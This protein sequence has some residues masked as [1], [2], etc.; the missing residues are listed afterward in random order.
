M[1]LLTT[2]S[3]GTLITIAVVLAILCMVVWL[4]RR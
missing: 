3:T 4:V 1:P 2:I